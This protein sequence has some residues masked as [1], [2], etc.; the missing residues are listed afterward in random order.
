MCL[1]SRDSASPLS[2]PFDFRAA[3]TFPRADKDL[4]MNFASL[5]LS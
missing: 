2:L 4:L 3:T 1:A 5:I